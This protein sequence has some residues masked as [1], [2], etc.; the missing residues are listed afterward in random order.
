MLW[1]LQW[2]RSQ[3]CPDSP[4]CESLPSLPRSKLLLEANDSSMFFLLLLLLTDACE[5]RRAGAVAPPAADRQAQHPNQLHQATPLLPA[6][7]RVL[8]QLAWAGCSCLKRP[9]GCSPFISP[10]GF[11]ITPALSSK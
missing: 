1:L 11:T 4:P 2:C 10:L 6:A 9:C 5:S 3:T 7:V 8:L